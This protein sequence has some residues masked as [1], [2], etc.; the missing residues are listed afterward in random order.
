ME[1]ENLILKA[2]SRDQKNVIFLP[3]VGKEA[4]PALL[5][6]FDA[7]YIG[8]K[9]DP[10]F[11]F[12]V[13]PNKLMDYMM[14]AKPVIHAIKAGNNMVAESSCGISIS[15]DNPDEI[16]DAV[17]R[18]MSLP[19]MERAKMGQNGKTY[20]IANHDYRIL[21]ERFIAVVEG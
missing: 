13:S 7:L 19:K 9:G 2:K 8:L 6:E 15:P 1:K 21:A 5:D 4:I 10:L 17:L 16:S 11:M 3:T 14:A 18:L 20:I 12:G